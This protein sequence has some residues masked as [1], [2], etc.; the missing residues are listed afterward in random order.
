M[1][2]QVAVRWRLPGGPFDT[3]SDPGRL[4][5]QH[6]R[7]LVAAGFVR[8]T[9]ARTVSRTVPPGACF[10]ASCSA[11]PFVSWGGSQGNGLSITI[12]DCE[13]RSADTPGT[14]G[15]RAGCSNRTAAMTRMAAS[16]TVARPTKILRIDRTTA[17]AG[18]KFQ[19][20]RSIWW[21]PVADT[22]RTIEFGAPPRTPWWTPI[23][24]LGAGRRKHPDACVS[25]NVAGSFGR[26]RQTLGWIIS[27]DAG[28]TYSP[29]EVTALKAATSGQRDDFFWARLNPRLE[30]GEAGNE[31]PLEIW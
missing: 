22:N 19:G 3:I 20:C 18:R 6:R 29:R 21:W 4:T 2:Y 26:V 16:P 28:E 5:T 8:T 11:W 31:R 7:G 13:S 14:D 24:T 15:P 30:R 23:R 17:R 1:T 25:T 12:P 27:V 10:S 9:S